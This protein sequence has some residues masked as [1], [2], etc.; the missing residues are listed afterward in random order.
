MRSLPLFLI[1][2][3]L[4]CNKLSNSSSI[5]LQYYPNT[6]ILKKGLVWKYYLHNKEKD[7]QTK[8]DILYIKRNI[9]DHTIFEEEY[10]AGFQLLYSSKIDI[11]SNR[12]ILEKQTSYRYRNLRKLG[13]TENKLL[14]DKDI[15]ID[16]NSNQAYIDKSDVVDGNGFRIIERQIGINDSISDDKK[17]KIIDSNRSLI[18]I[19]DHKNVD[20][21]IFNSSS[22]YEEGLGL[23]S[24]NRKSNDW[25][26][27]MELDEIITTE[28]F[29]KRSHHRTHRVGYID[30]LNT[31]D[32]YKLFKPCDSV[33][34]IADYYNDRKAEFKGGKGRLRSI[35]AETL[36][37]TIIKGESG[38]LTYRFVINCE[39]QAGWFVTEEANLNY[40][41]IK[42][43]DETRLLF[44]NILKTEK[45]WTNLMVRD[46]PRDAYTYITFKLIDGKIVEILP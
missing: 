36:D 20:T 2:S 27:R 31:I 14:I 34:K 6:T 40:D 38:Y 29:N 24:R 44:Y 39:G 5:G 4:S 41:K 18:R 43:R 1:V 10:D 30:T 17:I 21:F 3:I 16:W 28:E 46:I 35:L 8:T 26:V 32:D 15:S 22:T 33:S 23:T 42:F 19:V 11:K 45:E 7:S 13:Y 9:E 25:T 12:W 37:T